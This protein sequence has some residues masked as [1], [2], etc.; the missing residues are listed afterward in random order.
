MKV[1]VTSTAASQLALNNV[2]V[3]CEW[4][5][6]NVNEYVRLAE[7]NPDALYIGGWFVANYA[8]WQLYRAL[9]GDIK[10]VIVHWYGSDVLIAKQFHDRGQRKMFEELATDRFVNIPPNDKIKAE[11]KEWISLDTTDPLNVPAETTYVE[12][13]KPEQ[14]TIGIYMPCERLDFF[15]FMPICDALPG[16]DYRVIFYH[17]LPMTQDLKKEYAERHL[18]NAEFRYGLSREQY[19]KTIEDCSCLL[20][21]PFHD[22]YSIS[23]AEFLMAGR[24]V[25][26]QHDA[27]EWPSLIQGELSKESVL[28]ALKWVEEN[29]DVPKTVQD[30]YRDRWSPDKFKSRLL[31]RV[32]SQWPEV[33]F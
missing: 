25:V 17:W 10:K 9:I 12:M 3:P 5:F 16:T 32:N 30:Y 2:S 8:N 28:A 26:S 33:V 13:P 20:R 27:P 1:A 11:L 23:L 24:P 22:A 7:Y 19:R 4:E 18:G 6:F 14:F 15:N 21:I 29:P 31:N